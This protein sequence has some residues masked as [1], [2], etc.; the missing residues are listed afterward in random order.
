ME[1][2]TNA[3]RPKKVIQNGKEENCRG[4]EMAEDMHGPQRISSNKA[5]SGRVWNPVTWEIL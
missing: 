3:V 2:V 4:S 1:G 5:G